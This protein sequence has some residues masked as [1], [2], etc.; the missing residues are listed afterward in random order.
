M[1][2]DAQ[3]I[4]YRPAIVHRDDIVQAIPVLFA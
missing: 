4:S 3:S 2:T 1:T